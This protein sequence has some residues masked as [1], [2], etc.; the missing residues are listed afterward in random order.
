M[1]VM[2]LSTEWEECWLLSDSSYLRPVITRFWGMRKESGPVCSG[3][4]GGAAQS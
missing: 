1:P 4:E 2:F 3:L